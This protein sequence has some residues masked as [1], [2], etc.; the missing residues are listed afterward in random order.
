MLAA[1]P[2]G[3]DSG[4]AP[5]INKRPT[6]GTERR[7]GELSSRRARPPSSLLHE[8]PRLGCLFNGALAP[9]AAASPVTGSVPWRHASATSVAH[10]RSVRTAAVPIRESTARMWFLP[11]PYCRGGE[12]HARL[13]TPIDRQSMPFCWPDGAIARA[14]DAR[15]RS[16]GPTPGSSR[17]SSASVASRAASTPS[18]GGT[19]GQTRSAP[20][21]RPE[22]RH[23]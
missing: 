7:A 9:R 18:S 5:T 14:A 8:G 16:R 10:S 1:S 11:E 3:A 6:S 19:H 15:E 17:R 4:A 2:E 13:A 20:S 22:R 23:R 12:R 21:T